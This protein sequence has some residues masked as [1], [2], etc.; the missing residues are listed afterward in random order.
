MSVDVLPTSERVTWRGAVARMDWRQGEHVTLIG[1]TGVGKTELMAKLLALPS[2]WVF[3][4]TKRI[5][6]TVADLATYRPRGIK[7]ADELHPEVG[8]RFIVAPRWNLKLDADTQND[9]HARVFSRV[10]HRAF[11]QTGWCVAIDELEFIN[12]DLKI[13]APVDRLLRQGRSQGNS[14]FLATQRPRHVTLHAYEQATHLFIWRMADM[15]NII[16]AAELAGVNRQLV[17]AIVPTLGEHDVLYINTITG[18][19]F[20]TNTRWGE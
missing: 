18:N 6:A 14:M 12:R 17:S 19:T 5:D 3:L 11:V 4:S 16:R 20:T 8:R 9:I 15:G 10:L 7:T 13:G 2:W 1:P